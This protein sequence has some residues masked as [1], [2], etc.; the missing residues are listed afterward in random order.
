[1]TVLENGASPGSASET[2]LT[3]DVL[4]EKLNKFSKFEFLI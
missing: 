3:E 4:L 2:D 1:V